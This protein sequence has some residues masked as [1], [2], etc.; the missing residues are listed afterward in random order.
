MSD[1]MNAQT[2]CEERD[3]AMCGTTA[4]VQQFKKKSNA[5]AFEIRIIP[6][7]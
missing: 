3:K 5:H 7:L 1:S 4:I 6:H 2:I